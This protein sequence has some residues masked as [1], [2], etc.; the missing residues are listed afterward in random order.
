[1]ALLIWYILAEISLEAFAG[2]VQRATFEGMEVVKG[3]ADAQ[4]KRGLEGGSVA[5]ACRIS[6]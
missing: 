5:L 6:C 4:V 3:H 2:A 1:M